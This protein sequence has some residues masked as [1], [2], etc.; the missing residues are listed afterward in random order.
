MLCVA[1]PLLAAMWCLPGACT[2]AE[3]KLHRLVYQILSQNSGKYVAVTRGGRVNAHA[4]NPS[5]FC[6]IF[7]LLT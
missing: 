3:P 4:N 2:P 7:A 6:I 1:V 5:K